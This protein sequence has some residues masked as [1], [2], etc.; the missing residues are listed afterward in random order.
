MSVFS[1]IAASSA[2]SASTCADS[3]ENAATSASEAFVSAA[4]SA[5]AFVCFLISSGS[6]AGPDG[7]W[8]ASVEVPFVS[9]PAAASIWETSSVPASV[10]ASVF[11]VP[12]M[13]QTR[14]IAVVASPRRMVFIIFIK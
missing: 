7:V 6:E 2:F 10:A 3:F 14:L 12:A 1:V 8:D 11:M 4:S 9:S 13:R 5:A